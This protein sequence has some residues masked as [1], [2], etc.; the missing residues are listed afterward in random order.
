[1]SRPASKE[2]TSGAR[3]PEARATRGRDDNSIE[4]RDLRKVFRLYQRPAQRF[5]EALHPFRKTYHQKF[6]ALDGITFTIPRGETVAFIGK[7]G[8]GKSTLLKLITGIQTPTSGTVSVDGRISALLELGTGFNPELTGVENVFFTGA[9]MGIPKSVMET[10]LDEVLAFADIGDYARQPVRSYSSGMFVRLAFAVAVH[11]DPDILVIDEALSVGDM[12]FQ[13]KCYR[14]IRAFKERGITILFVSH[15]MGAVNNFCDRCL[16]LK[17]GKIER[18][19]VPSEVVRA[20]AAYMNYDASTID[21]TKPEALPPEAGHAAWQ[22]VGSCA[23][24]GDRGAEVTRVSFVRAGEQGRLDVV[25]G[26][27][28]VELAMEVVFHQDVAQPLYGVLLKDT[29]GNQILSI[30][31]AAYEFACAPRKAGEKVVF[32]FAFKFPLIRNGEYSISY[33]VAEGTQ[34]AHVEHHWVHDALVIQ[35]ANHGPKNSLGCYMVIEDVA[36]SEKSSASSTT[37]EDVGEVRA[38]APEDRARE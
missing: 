5:F 6:A 15:D 18:D 12:R 22:D 19:G 9:I 8:A 26:N 17:E 7:N 34:M 32:R 3:S 4:V 31:T 35:V 28:D 2:G 21:A 11:V 37:S 29:Y 20:Y 16:W 13:Q 38:Q 25:V 10:R 23:S 36:L 30:N 24:F 14:R 27:E 33:A 1:M